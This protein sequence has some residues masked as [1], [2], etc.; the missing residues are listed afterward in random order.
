MSKQLTI[1]VQY[2]LLDEPGCVCHHYMSWIG[3]VPFCT[4]QWIDPLGE[5]YLLIYL[6]P[7]VEEYAAILIGRWIQMLDSY[8]EKIVFYVCADIQMI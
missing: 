4:N 1:Y 5:S 2:F 8:F 6:V 3:M 7:K